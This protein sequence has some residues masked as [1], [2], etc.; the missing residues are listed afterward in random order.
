MLKFLRAEFGPL[1][2]EEIS[3]ARIEEFALKLK[4]TP[5]KQHSDRLQTPA[6]CNRK[7]AL[8]R[9]VLRM[10][11]REG[12]IERLP[13]VEL[14]PED[15]ERDKVL[16]EEEFARLHEQS[17]AHLKSILLCAWETGMRKG[18]I[19][20]LTWPKVNLRENF[21]TLESQDTKT[22]R[23][24]TIPISQKLRDTLLS[25][26]QA[27]NKV[28]ELHQ[29][30]LVS[31]TGKPV[32]NIQEAFDNA[33]SRAGL[34]DVHFHDLRRSFVTRKITEGWDRD[35]VEAI[36]GHRTDK[37][38]ARYNKPSLETLRAVV[39]GTPP[40][41]SSTAVVKLLSNESGQQTTTVLS[42]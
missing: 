35:H 11:W 19:L 38:F 33:V 21:I 29:H 40:F 31:V 2:L 9:H 1:P 32:K 3:Y 7:L 28:T 34:K 20:S 4:N 18:E 23:R 30:V 13:A 42:A 16:T 15:N 5:G 39:D 41:S 6:T 27:R 26:R 17:A 37:V 8:L 14:F 24:R 36:T 25:L 12:L 22:G 10:A